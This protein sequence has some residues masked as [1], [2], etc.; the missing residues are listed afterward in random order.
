MLLKRIPSVVQPTNSGLQHLRMH[1]RQC[2]L[3]LFRLGQ[4]VLLSL[5]ARKW[6][7]APDNVFL[8]QRTPIDGTLARSNPVLQFTQ[9]MVV[10]QATGFGPAAHDLLLSCVGID[11]IGVV[12]CQHSNSLPRIDDYNTDSKCLSDPHRGE[13]KSAGSPCIPTLTFQIQ[14]GTYS[15]PNPSKWLFIYVRLL[16]IFGHRIKS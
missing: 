10:D 8:L 12:E 16:S 9:S 7:I 1:L 4:V 15:S 5:V 13:S 6:R 11:S 14:R 3:F 2:G